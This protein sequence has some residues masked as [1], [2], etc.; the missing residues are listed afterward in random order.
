VTKEDGKEGKSFFL[1][2]LDFGEYVWKS[3]GDCYR[4]SRAIANYFMHHNLSPKTD[5]PEG[6][7][8]FVA[9]YAKNREEWVET[10]LGC[11]MTGIT[12]VTLYDTLGKDATEYILDQ[13]HIKTLVCS[14]DKIKLVADLK[15]EGKIQKLSHII[16]FDKASQDLINLA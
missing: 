3:F 16:Y 7:L 12:V 8:R 9:I 13:T 6:H 2:C 14:A 15:K 11:M 1:T 4:T 10:D 5:T